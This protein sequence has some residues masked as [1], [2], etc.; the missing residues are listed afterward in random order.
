METCPAKA[1]IFG[2]L[3]DPNDEV[4]KLLAKHA[5]QAIKPE[6]GTYPKVFYIGADADAM[7]PFAG[8][9]EWT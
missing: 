7:D 5:F 9:E 2:N 4:A 3:L 6:M 1:R 8:R